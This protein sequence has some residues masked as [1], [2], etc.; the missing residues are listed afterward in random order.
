MAVAGTVTAAELRQRQAPMQPGYRQ[1]RLCYLRSVAHWT[2]QRGP[3]ESPPHPWMAKE[4]P[5]KLNTNEPIDH[6][7]APAEIQPPQA[8]ADPSRT[9]RPRPIRAA[10]AE[11]AAPAE[12]GVDTFAPPPESTAENADSQATAASAADALTGPEPAIFGGAGPAAPFSIAPETPPVETASAEQIASVLDEPLRPGELF[13]DA[14]RIDLVR[15]IRSTPFLLSTMVVCLIAVTA[16]IRNLVQ[17]ET[18]V[19]TSV[20]FNNYTRLN[21]SEQADLQLEMSRLLR[22]L[23]LRTQA[24][25]ILHRKAPELHA[26]FLNSG[27]TFHRLDAILWDP[28]GTLRL[29]V[30]SDDPASDVMRLCAVSEAFYL[31]L[32]DRARLRDQFRDELKRLEALHTGLL[33]EDG[34]IKRRVDEL[35]PDAQRYADLK[36]A[37]Q[38]MER[39]L[40]LADESNPLRLVARQNLARLALQVGDAR[41]LSLGRD[42]LMARRIALQGR[43]DETAD[44]TAKMRRRIELFAWPDPPD[45]KTLR[46]YDTRPVRTTAMRIAWLSIIMIFGATILLI[47]L[48]DQRMAEHVRRERRERLKAKTTVSP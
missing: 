5:D 42:E 28:D 10:S 24:W 47:H 41:Q 32:D 12:T 26:G 1:S 19:E 16:S 44:S 18:Y 3:L 17:T 14:P 46:I 21:E 27:L 23:P 43:I 8:P 7:S 39:Y 38:A 9:R 35:L 30:D 37:M 33:Q 45:A 31:Q 40:Q 25:E 11:N 48:Y 15:I 6:A 13:A 29:R 22:T 34:R 36:Q 2:G 4:T 20:H